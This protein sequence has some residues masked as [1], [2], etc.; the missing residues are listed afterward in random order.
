MGILLR[1]KDWTQTALGPVDNWS[2][3]LLTMV[4]LVMASTHPMSMWWGEESVLIY[5]DGYIP[6]AGELHPAAFGERAKDHWHGLW[7]VL[8]PIIENG[9]KGESIYSEDQCL[10][11]QRNGYTEVYYFLCNTYGRKPILRGHISLYEKKAATFA[12]F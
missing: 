6:I 9:M 10:I 5:N 11:M 1:D 2:Q 4:S 12:V 8:E 7:N 3:T